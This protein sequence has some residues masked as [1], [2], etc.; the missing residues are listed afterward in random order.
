MK[1]N[2][3]LFLTIQLLC[4]SV[5]ALSDEIQYRIVPEIDDPILTFKRLPD[6]VVHEG[7]TLEYELTDYYLGTDIKFEVDEDIDPFFGTMVFV[8]TTFP[9]LAKKCFLPSSAKEAV[10]STAIVIQ[11]SSGN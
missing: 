6:I 3:Y 2:P 9:L 8:N 10:Q 7:E 11:T 5:L 4:A 1:K